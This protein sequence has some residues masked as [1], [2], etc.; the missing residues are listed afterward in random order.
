MSA[1]QLPIDSS[2]AGLVHH[3]I[4]FTARFWSE[5]AGAI[6]GYPRL[7]E[8]I[9]LVPNAQL[10]VALRQALAAELAKPERA[11]KA[12]L[13]PRILPWPEWVA[14]LEDAGAARAQTMRLVELF[15]ALK[16]TDWL[17]RRL[18]AQASQLWALARQ[19]LSICDEV[20]LGL[21][22]FDVQGEARAI[23]ARLVAAV[24]GSYR[25]RSWSI[26]S[27]E[28]ELVLGIWRST[29][30]RDDA[31][32]RMLRGLENLAAEASR[33]LVV[34]ATEPLPPHAE[35]FLLRYAAR[36]SVVRWEIDLGQSVKA[37]PALDAAWPELHLNPGQDE[38]TPLIARALELRNQGSPL[39]HVQIIEHAGLEDEAACAADTILAWLRAGYRNIA[40]VALD[41]L[42]ARRVRALL[43]RAHVLVRDEAG[44]KFST[45]TVSG[46]LMRW[47]ELVHADETHVEATVL[48]D[49]VKSP[50]ALFGLAG[51]E[52]IVAELEWAIRQENVARGWPRIAQALNRAHQ[53]L[54]AERGAP[55]DPALED[56][57]PEGLAR[58]RISRI[59][60]A[61]EVLARVRSTAVPLR[62]RRS[63]GAHF[64]WLKASL[65]Q[66]GMAQ[67]FGADPVGR[68]LL[69]Q[70][71]E[72]AHDCL[73]AESGS[74][75]TYS[76]WREFVADALENTTFREAAVDSPVV[77]TSLAGAAYRHFEAIFVLGVDAAHFPGDGPDGLF[78]N[79]NIRA[80]LGL[81]DSAAHQR[82]ALRQLALLL[83]ATPEASLSWQS[84]KNDRPN[85]AAGALERLIMLHE[86]AFGDNLVRP[87]RWPRVPI[88]PQ[89]RAR[90][91][92]GAAGRV[93]AEVSASGYNL[94]ISCPYRYYVRHML[95]LAPLEAIREDVEKR[96]YG[97]IVHRI[98]ERYHAQVAPASSREAALALL[99]EVSASVF[100]EAPGSRAA[101]LGYRHRWRSLIEPY[102]DWWLAWSREG[103][104][105]AHTELALTRQLDLPDGGRV[106]LKGRLDRVDRHGAARA[107]LD[108]K[109]RSKQT[110]QE[111]LKRPGEDIQLPFY[112]LLLAAEEDVRAAYLSVDREKVDLVEVGS[113]FEELAKAV[114]ERIERDFARL[115]QGQGLPANGSEATCG[116]CDDRGLCRKGQWSER[117]LESDREKVTLPMSGPAR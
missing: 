68:A 12:L 13:L 52:A 94:F 115:H 96:D 101:L 65:A 83:A 110:L 85:P 70:L 40:L 66:T 63:L 5:L 20:T 99:A 108:Y 14:T 38:P 33:R 10:A 49:W 34:I 82:T 4:P 44:W 7:E 97:E 22:R 57:G 2:P 28:A 88:T 29:L 8:W 51:K 27:E 37:Q 79:G 1:P 6:L 47:L 114:S 39:R 58:A 42:T 55:V 41:R 102:V 53:R 11:V 77:A 84:V 71:E 91:A 35:A 93:P 9:V 87:W 60:R 36:Q 80:E 113:G 116:R 73:G 19:L 18:G 107:I 112:R 75:F 78:L 117:P 32:A 61:L 45:A 26:C 54:R 50:H 111:G 46:S 89:P 69:L 72:L 64:D 15:N 67:S 109:A 105:T 90:P 17:T 62:G 92:P 56:D 16:A 100:D 59:E 30:T 31:P 43:E 106:L 23:E 98:L 25:D 74:G 76:E 81:A 103:W 104:Q 21:G 24:K 3:P 95:G 86:A 48:L